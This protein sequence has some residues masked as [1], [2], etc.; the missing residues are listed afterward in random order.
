[1]KYRR[2]L[3]LTTFLLFIA[4]CIVCFFVGF[5]ISRIDLDA[6][7]VEGSNERISQLV[8]EC[9]IKYKDDNLL[10]LNSE[11]LKSEIEEL[12]FYYQ[13][14]SIDKVYPNTL[15]V[16]VTE[17]K[18]CF[19]LKFDGM[20]YILDDDFYVLRVSSKKENNVDGLNNVELI[21]NSNYFQS[22]SLK[23][24][25]RLDILDTKTRNVLEQHCELIFDHKFDLD[26][27]EIIVKEKAYY[28]YDCIVTMNEGV[29]YEISSYNNSCLEKVQALYKHYEALENKSVGFYYVDIVDGEE[30]KIVNK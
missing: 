24:G 1:M 2:I 19:A 25:S 16:K 3:M 5:K 23:E 12:S 10:F 21:L 30:I 17:R 7:S 22:D 8:E 13:V 20:Y 15:K 14:D 11:K 27:I 28:R 18:E 29:K 26:S 9:L 6:T 4:V